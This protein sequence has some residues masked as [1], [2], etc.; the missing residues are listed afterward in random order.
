[1]SVK[2]RTPDLPACSAVPQPTASPR[3]PVC[4]WKP[5]DNQEHFYKENIG[6]WHKIELKYAISC[7]FQYF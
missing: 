3:A 2:I 6:L 5:S 4:E 7:G 1:M